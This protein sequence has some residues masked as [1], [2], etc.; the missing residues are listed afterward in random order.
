MLCFSFLIDVDVPVLFSFF[1]PQPSLFLFFL[2]SL[3]L[4]K[5]K[6][7]STQLPNLRSYV[8]QLQKSAGT[9]PKT[10][11]TPDEL[12]KQKKKLEEEQAKELASLFAVAIKQPKL[13]PGVDPKSV[14]CE[15]Y[16]AG[17][18]AKGFKC[19]YSHDL[20]VERKTQK[21]DLFSDRRAGALDGE[22]EE[23]MEDWD[24]V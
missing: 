7:T 24:Q 4:E 22:E 11:P 8:Q 10:G 12:R 2:L 16:R 23:G 21:I 5:K 18:C 15:F 19:K 9:G 13:A 14:V 17:K 20:A 3:S 6:K 1:K